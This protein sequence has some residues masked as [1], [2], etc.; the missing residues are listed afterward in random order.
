MR[1]PTACLPGPRPRSPFRDVSVAAASRDTSLARPEDARLV[2]L[3]HAADVAHGSM[4]RYLY[5]AYSLSVPGVPVAQ[6]GAVSAWQEVMLGV[7]A[8]ERQQWVSVQ[9][10]LRRLGAPPHV[11]RARRLALEPLT[12]NVLAAYVAEASPPD[13]SGPWADDVHR[14]VQASGRRRR[15]CSEEPAGPGDGWGE[16]A[17]GSEVQ[18]LLIHGRAC[19]RGN[20]RFVALLETFREM[21]ALWDGAVPVRHVAVDPYLLPDVAED[22]EDGRPAAGRDLI[23]HPTARLWGHLFNL[24]YGLMLQALVQTVW[25]DD[26]DDGTW[27]AELA[28]MG[29][30]AATLTALPLKRGGGEKTAGAPFLLPPWSG[31]GEG[32]SAVREAAAAGQ[33]LVRRLSVTASASSLAF[34]YALRNSDA[35][36]M[37]GGDVSAPSSDARVATRPRR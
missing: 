30:I 9:H 19:R 5:A 18:R 12:P 7:A 27:R 17:L 22:G 25:A 13:W 21:T 29:T 32:A 28:H 14:R 36:R 33:A 6:S 1:D 26:P 11:G 15:A 16:P 34:L 20:A 2:A 10:L 4:V 3:Q 23:T 24:R 37:A 31:D 35:A 8:E